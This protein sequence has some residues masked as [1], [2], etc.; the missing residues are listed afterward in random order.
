MGIGA[1]LHFFLRP[2]IHGF[3]SHLLLVAG[4]N[5]ILAVSLPV[6]NGFTR[7]LSIGHAGFMSLGGYTAAAIMYYGSLRFFGSPATHGLAGNLLFGSACLAG[8]VVAALA[9]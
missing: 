2:N 6:V 1:S 5:I 3:Q 4:I 8:G 7:Q 9:G